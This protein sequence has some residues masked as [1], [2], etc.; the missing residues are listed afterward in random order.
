MPFYIY[1]TT[2]QNNRIARYM[3]TFPDESTVDQWYNDVCKL[4]ESNPGVGKFSIEKVSPEWYTL[5]TSDD[6]ISFIDNVQENELKK[7]KSKC[8]WLLL[9]DVGGR[10]MPIIPKQTFLSK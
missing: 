9:N 8:F 7:Y 3:G 4:K 2:R 1:V 6:A 10:D 5:E